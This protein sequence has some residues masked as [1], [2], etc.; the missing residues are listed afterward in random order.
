MRK[1]LLLVPAVA[2]LGACQATVDDVSGD[3][4][5]ERCA[6]RRAAIAAFEAQDHLSDVEA[7]ILENY[8]VYVTTACAGV[9]P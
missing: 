3:T 7:G 4:I 8:R 2:L 5:E 1:L 6:K 9:G